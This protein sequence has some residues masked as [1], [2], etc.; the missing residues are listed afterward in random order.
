MSS[1]HSGRK[2]C[3]SRDCR[4]IRLCRRLYLKGNRDRAPTEPSL[5]RRKKPLYREG[6]TTWNSG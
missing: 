3:I 4:L 6:N 2:G 1:N 5:P